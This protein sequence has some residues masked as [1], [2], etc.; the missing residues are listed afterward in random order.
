MLV[1]GPHIAISIFVSALL[2]AGCNSPVATSAPSPVT[3]NA[4]NYTSSQVAAHN[5]VTDCWITIDS[6]VYNLTSFIPLHSGGDK[7]INSCG[8]DATQ[9]LKTSHKPI[10]NTIDSY[11]IGTLSK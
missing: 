2:L 7:I 6:H 9:F 1:R 8:S 11:Q 3:S 4:A 10:D 5:T